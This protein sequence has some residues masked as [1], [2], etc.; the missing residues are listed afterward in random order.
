MGEIQHF[1]GTGA[2]FWTFFIFQLL[3]LLGFGL[4]TKYSTE[5]DITID[6]SSLEHQTIQAMYPAYQDV[7]VMVN[8]GRARFQS[9]VPR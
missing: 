7:H 3:M 4:F 9:V 8:P 1:D 5:A 2:F 6:P